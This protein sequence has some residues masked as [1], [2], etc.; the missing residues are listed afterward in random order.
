M[1]SLHVLKVVY[2]E[3]PF[4]TSENHRN[5]RKTF[6]FLCIRLKF[7]CVQLTGDSSFSTATS[8][9]GERFDDCLTQISAQPASP[10]RSGAELEVGVN[11]HCGHLVI[12]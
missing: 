9:L 7:Y 5:L 8:N 4:S 12:L 11:D 6:H 3:E 10:I 2:L 1:L